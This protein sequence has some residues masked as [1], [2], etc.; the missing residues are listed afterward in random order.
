MTAVLSFQFSVFSSQFS[1]LSSQF[2]VF[3]SQFSV[4]SFQF[5]VL[6]SQFS[7]FSFQFSVFSFQFSVFGFQ[8]SVFS[9]RFSVLGFQLP[10]F[11]G[12]GAFR[13]LRAPKTH[14]RPA[15]GN[16]LGTIGRESIHSAQRAN[17]SRMISRI[18]GP[19]GRIH[20]SWSM[21]QGVALGWENY[22][23]FGPN[24]GYYR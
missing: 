9:F 15:Q 3:S 13:T 8:F 21:P 12:R 23:A 4:F 16:A 22:R 7:V 17:G 1:V 11:N 5:S 2:S 6:S 24:P 14:V 18:I 19:L 10:F 20:V